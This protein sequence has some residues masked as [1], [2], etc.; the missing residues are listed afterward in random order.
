MSD[1]EIS[2]LEQVSQSLG[3]LQPERVEAVLGLIEGWKMGLGSGVG[4]PVS[5][6]MARVLVN[7]WVLGILPDRFGAG[8]AKMLA[9]G[10]IWCVPVVLSYPV[11]GV[12]GQVGEVLISA[13]SGGIISATQPDV[14][15][16]HAT[17]LYEARS[18]D[19]EAAFS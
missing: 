19:I 6:V 11:V 18:H 13:F 7:D 5:A 2:K 1:V 16:S 17:K 8:E 3:E 15:R 4:V 10:D 14:M 12:I 9:A